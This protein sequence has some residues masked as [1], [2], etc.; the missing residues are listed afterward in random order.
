MESKTKQW[1]MNENTNEGETKT[2]KKTNKK[3][4]LTDEQKKVRKV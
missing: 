3:K 1:R 2:L 4:Q